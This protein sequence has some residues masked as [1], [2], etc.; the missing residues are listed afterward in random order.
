[1]K[2]DEAGTCDLDLGNAFDGAERGDD[3]LSELA[4]IHA[5]ILGFLQRNTASIVAMRKFR[6]KGERNLS[7]ADLDATG[8]ER[9]QKRLLYD[10]FYLH[11]A[12]V[13]PEVAAQ[14]RL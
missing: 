8:F 12:I 3:L 6:R 14:K 11:G 10:L 5:G 2:I 4:R 13:P 9:L 1:M 7:S